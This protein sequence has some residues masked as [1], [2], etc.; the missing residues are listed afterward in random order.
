MNRKHNDNLSSTL[1]EQGSLQDKDEECIKV[2]ACNDHPKVLFIEPFYGGSHKQLM[3]LLV[4]STHNYLFSKLIN[5]I[6]VLLLLLRD[7]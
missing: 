3:D 2:Q 1:V 6:K 7:T 5:V 4:E